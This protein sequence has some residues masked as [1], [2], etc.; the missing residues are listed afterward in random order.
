MSETTNLKN[1]K[2]VKVQKH[3]Y[4]SWALYHLDPDGTEWK[5]TFFDFFAERLLPGRGSKSDAR[6]TRNNYCRWVAHFL[7]FMIESTNLEVECG[8]N[9]MSGLVLVNLIRKYPIFL[10]EANESGDPLI[11]EVANRLKSTPCKSSSQSAYIAAINKY[12]D[13]S[14]DFNVTMRELGI[15]D[16][17]GVPF[18]SNFD[19]FPESFGK[20]PLPEKER[21]ALYKNSML[22]GVISGGAKLKRIAKL[23]PMKSAKGESDTNQHTD[24]EEF[25]D[26]T[27]FPFEHAPRL[28]CEGFKSLRDK[29]LFCLLMACGCRLSEALLLTWRDIDTKRQL[30]RLRCP[31][32]K[33]LEDY[34]GYFT[35][36][37]EILDL[38]WKGRVTERTSLIEPFKTHFWRLLAEYQKSSE[39][40]WTTSHNFV[41]QTIKGDDKGTP[42][43]VN[44]FSN[45][46]KAMVDACKRIGISP[47]RP[48]SLRH[49]YGVYC[50]NFLPFDD[51]SF[52]MGLLAVKDLMGHASLK[53]TEKYAIPDT[54]LHMLRQRIS[55]AA[56]R[57]FTVDTSRDLRLEMLRRE[58]DLLEAEIA[59]EKELHQQQIGNSGNLMTHAC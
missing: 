18:F 59:R 8:R 45:L 51:G 25:F 11:R 29:V 5:D 16:I 15:T 22:A 42:L 35:S 52:G 6:N 48:H 50:L 33:S 43:I 26:G 1:V 21:I 31:W 56:L 44:D 20:A 13:L 27:Y 39:F 37:S 57:D 41:F 9:E 30:V 12:L 47:M 55:Y 38:P 19:L 10:A 32:E 28:L 36:K 17:N 4:N 58:Y 3:G 46:G 24:I 49:M 7:D 34:C 54:Q 40:T 53:S 23:K 14:E 2:L